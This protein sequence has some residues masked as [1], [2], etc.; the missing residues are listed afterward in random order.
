MASPQVSTPHTKTHN[1]RPSLSGSVLLCPYLGSGTRGFLIPCQLH[2]LGHPPQILPSPHSSKL[3]FYLAQPC[4]LLSRETAWRGRSLES[5]QH[6]GPTASDPQATARADAGLLM[7]A[8]LPP[9]LSHRILL[10]PQSQSVSFMKALPMGCG[11]AGRVFT[12]KGAL[13][14]SQDS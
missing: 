7:A 12:G 4:S 14:R 8:E 5:Q 3:A 2:L 9:F 1:R 6:A 11:S 10:V 13:A